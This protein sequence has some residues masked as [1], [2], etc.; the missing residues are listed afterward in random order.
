[1]SVLLADSIDCIPSQSPPLSSGVAFGGQWNRQRMEKLPRNGRA[2]W[3]S[4]NTYSRW[5]PVSAAGLPWLMARRYAREGA[6]LSLHPRSVNHHHL[7]RVGVAASSLLLAYAPV[8]A[9]IHLAIGEDGQTERQSER[10]TNG[11]A[12]YPS[13]CWVTIADHAS[14]P[15]SSLKRRGLGLRWRNATLDREHRA[16]F[17]RSDHSG[18]GK[19]PTAKTNAQLS[20]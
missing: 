5:Y 13:P 9:V 20:R 8:L 15:P 17:V 11:V 19:T 10:A 18:A 2:V 6:I 12:A 4:R 14:S 7:P 16:S 3:T 1:M